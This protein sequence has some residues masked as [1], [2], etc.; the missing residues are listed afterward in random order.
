MVA[1][2]EILV[3]W[4]RFSAPLVLGN[5]PCEVAGIMPVAVDVAPDLAPSILGGVESSETSCTFPDL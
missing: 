2:P 5:G 4:M 1:P 3:S